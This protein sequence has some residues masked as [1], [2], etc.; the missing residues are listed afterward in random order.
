MPV[1][2]LR[3]LVDHLLNMWTM[4]V[5]V[6]NINVPLVEEVHTSKIYFTRL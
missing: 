6:Y 3:E 2:Y 5:N 1:Y 4:Q